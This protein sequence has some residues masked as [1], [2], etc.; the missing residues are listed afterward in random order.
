[1]WNSLCRG[2]GLIVFSIVIFSL[3]GMG[4]RPTASRPTFKITHTEVNA[5]LNQDR[6]ATLEQTFTYQGRL[7]HGPAI[8]I[9]S[10]G[11][12]NIK[13]NS[14]SVKRKGMPIHDQLSNIGQQPDPDVLKY[15]LEDVPNTYGYALKDGK[16]HVMINDPL[17]DGQTYTV[18]INVTEP[19]VI[20]KTGVVRWNVLGHAN[21]TDLGSV[22]AHIK[23]NAKTKVHSF[24]V[25]GADGV[26]AHG[27]KLNQTTV[28][29]KHYYQRD[30][31]DLRTNMPYAKAVFFTQFLHVWNDFGFN[32][33]VL[34]LL[35]AYFWYKVRRQMLG[36]SMAIPDIIVDD[37]PVAIYLSTGYF[38][39][40]LV[41]G[42]LTKRELLH[43]LQ[44]SGPNKSKYNYFNSTSSLER[45]IL[46]R[47]D[48][49]ARSDNDSDKRRLINSGADFRSEYPTAT[50]L[51][52][53]I[54]QFLIG[55]AIIFILFLLTIELGFKSSRIINIIYW[56]T[57]YFVCSIYLLFLF[58]MPNEFKQVQHQ[59]QHDTLIRLANGLSDINEIKNLHLDNAALWT[60]IVAWAVGIGLNKKIIKELG[61]RGYNL[62]LIKDPDQINTI[63]FSF[64]TDLG[65]AFIVS[66]DTDNNISGFGGDS[67]GGGDSGAGGW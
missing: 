23:N 65:S 28:N 62:G 66:T 54:I 3:V 31:L 45:I 38:N 12:N 39:K 16:L 46:K 9:K 56:L 41:T 67:F 20:S 15:L 48:M 50:S 35:I 63:T 49:A 52:K 10:G 7:A 57:F 1:M 34:V 58:Y 47:Y 25:Q 2:L 13:L 18:K 5:T 51:T 37:L 29:I 55:F 19:N 11:T 4:F 43:S 21:E 24:Y 44:K 17:E 60:D 26:L 27:S 53:R 42:L 64:N 36:S 40:R 30:H 32:W 14:V 61:Q 59:E 8:Q 22:E 6:S 33:I